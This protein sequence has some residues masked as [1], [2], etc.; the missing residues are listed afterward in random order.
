[1]VFDQRK[2]MHCR[3]RLDRDERAQRDSCS[4]A[5]EYYDLH[6]SLHRGRRNVANGEC[7]GSG[8]CRRGGDQRRVWGGERYASIVRAFDQPLLSRYV[9]VRGGL[10]PLVMELQRF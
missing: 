4:I 7:N 3:R 2:L 10:G 1:M 8:E 9:N 5:A 6:A